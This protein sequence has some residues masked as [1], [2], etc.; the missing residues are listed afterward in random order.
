MSWDDGQEYG[1]QGWNNPSPPGGS[2]PPPEPVYQ[3]PG[4][5]QPGHQQPGWGDPG[6]PPPKSG[7]STGAIVA[8]VIGALVLLLCG[9]CVVIGT[10]FSRA[11]TEFFEDLEESA[12]QA[13]ADS[14]ALEGDV[15]ISDCTVTDGGRVS[16][17][18]EIENTL[19]R[20]VDDVEVL[21]DFFNEDD[22]RVASGSA[23]FTNLAPGENAQ[24]VARDS[25]DGD[26]PTAV[27]C[28]VESLFVVP[29]VL[30]QLTE[31]TTTTR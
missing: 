18:V 1:D 8:I 27:R 26:I 30:G 2:M 6:P 29:T 15:S 28:E 12:A 14:K 31:A 16:A 4:F 22:I 21:V 10:A 7:L 20:T 11:S 9:G 25:V 19:N 24:I 17:A 3:Q 23:K 13:E 5:Q